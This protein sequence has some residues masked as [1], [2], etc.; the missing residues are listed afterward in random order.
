VKFPHG[1][2][3]VSSERTGQMPLFHCGMGRRPV[4]RWPV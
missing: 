3:T 1:R 2:A 4:S